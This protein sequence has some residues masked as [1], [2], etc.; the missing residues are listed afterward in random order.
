MKIKDAY[1]PGVSD[2]LGLP[3]GENIEVRDGNTTRFWTWA[4]PSAGDNRLDRVSERI[5]I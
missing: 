5:P 1:A 3:N 2:T 4:S